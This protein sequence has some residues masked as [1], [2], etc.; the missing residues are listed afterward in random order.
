MHFHCFP[1]CYD[2]KLKHRIVLQGEKWV[3]PK[4]FSAGLFIRKVV[5]KN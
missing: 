2:E 4:R 5:E 3:G 1:G